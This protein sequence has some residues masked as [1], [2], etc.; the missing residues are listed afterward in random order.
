VSVLA[1]D[2]F[3]R[4]NASTLGANWSAAPGHSQLKISGNSAVADL[5]NTADQVSVYTALGAW[6]NDQWSSAQISASSN[7]NAGGD[8]GA[9]VIVRT[10]TNNYSGY[11]GVVDRAASSNWGVF[12]QVN[13]TYTH[14]TGG[15]TTWADGDTFE[16]DVVGSTITF[17]KNGATLGSVSDSSIASG[18][19]GVGYSGTESSS[20]AISFDNWTGGDFSS[21][22]QTIS[23]PLISSTLAVFAPVLGLATL[24]A[25]FVA[26]A[27]S[28]LQP[29]VSTPGAS[30]TYSTS[31]PLT[32]NPISENGVWAGGASVGGSWHDA[33]TT[34]GHAVGTMVGNESGA[35]QFSDS[36]EMLRGSFPA[37][38]TIRTTVFDTGVTGDWHAEGEHFHRLVVTPGNIRG[39]EF[40]V[41]LQS[42]GDAYTTWVRWNGALGSFTTLNT[43]HVG[44]INAGDII[45]TKTIGTTL[46]AFVNGTLVNT[47]TDPTWTDGNPGFG[48][49]L[50]NVSQSGDSS[51]FGWDD[52]SIPTTGTI[53]APTIAPA[54]HLFDPTLISRN[55]I[56][57]PFLT[58][59]ATLFAPSLSQPTVE[60][61]LGQV[62]GERFADFAAPRSV[63]RIRV[64][65]IATN[66]SVVEIGVLS[67]K[68]IVR[69]GQVGLYVRATNEAGPNAIFIGFSAMVTQQQEVFPVTFPGG[70]SI[71]FDGWFTRFNDTNIG[72][73]WIE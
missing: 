3:N 68:G 19:P 71:A 72:H 46:Q 48:F 47:A 31:F 2:D 21:P 32:E 41:Q 1:S 16:I 15:T 35:A 56:A 66:R 58:P 65:V 55:S 70:G 14:L 18:Q 13:G 36:V 57:A 39:Y 40:N 38:V 22:S 20:A 12:R 45:T 9:A 64:E 60:S 73:V 5:S 69:F 42:R 4:A 59:A 63:S 61:D 25:P 11:W 37:D 7:A 62:E 30:A 53:L 50:R 49:F 34:G 6:P 27:L 33:R 8:Q 43:V 52:F 26:S 10:N 23:A 51:T 54:A 24:F 28:V 67:P 44:Q 29:N 17:K